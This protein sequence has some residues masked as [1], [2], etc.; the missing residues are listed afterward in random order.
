LF[1]LNEED[2]K[3]EKSARKGRINGEHH[4][5]GLRPIHTVEIFL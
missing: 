4:F 1:F 2:K 3:E 5:L